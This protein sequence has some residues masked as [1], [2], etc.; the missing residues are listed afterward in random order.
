MTQPDDLDIEAP[1]ADAAEQ[2]AYVEPPE[3]DGTASRSI[4]A[5]EWDAEEQSRAVPLDDD[6]R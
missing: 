6:Y 5:P 4:E 3:A 2:R 1:E